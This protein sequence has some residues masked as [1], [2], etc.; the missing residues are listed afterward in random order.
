[1]CYKQVTNTSSF[2]SHRNK[3]YFMIFHNLN[4]KRK[5]LIYLMKCT[6]CKAQYVGKTEKPF[7]IRLNNHRSDVSDPNAIPAC[8]RLTQ[9]NHQL[10]NHAKSTV[11]ETNTNKRQTKCKQRQT[12]RSHPGHSEETRKILDQYPRDFVPVR[13]NSRVQSVTYVSINCI[14]QVQLVFD[15]SM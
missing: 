6:L 5:C 10:K 15:S 11:I 14:H 9:N 7:N 13:Y 4:G 8:R 3:K 2:A 1:M 12:S